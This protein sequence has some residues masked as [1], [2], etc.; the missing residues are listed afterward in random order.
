M[1]SVVWVQCTTSAEC[2]NLSIAESTVTDTSKI[3]HTMGQYL[4]NLAHEVMNFALLRMAGKSFCRL[5][6][7]VG[8]GCDRRKDHCLRPNIG[9]GCGH[10]NDHEVSIVKIM[11]LVHL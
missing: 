4:I 9:H 8:C 1:G 11:W 10:Q 3:G 6:P 7:S 2:I 5:R